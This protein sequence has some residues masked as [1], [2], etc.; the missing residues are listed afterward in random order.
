MTAG[1][2][3]A[4]Y[5]RAAVPVDGGELAV[6]V[7]G[8]DAAGTPIL[9]VHG[10]TASHRAW[11]L[12]AEALSGTRVIAPDL[13]GRGRSSGLPAP[14]G[15]EQHADD[16]ARVLD[17]LGVER[18]V[19]AGHSMGGFVAVRLAERHPDRVERLVLVDGGLPVAAPAGVAPED[20]PAV[21][22]G[23]SLQR[24]GMR[25]ASPEEYVA[26]WR[27]HPAIGPWWDDA[28]ADYVAYDLVGEEP[29]LRSSADPD[30]VS[31]NALELDGSAGYAE[32][33]EALRLPIDFIRAPRGLLDAAPL[34]EPSV[35]AE[36]APRIPTMRVHEAHDVNHYTIVMTDAGLRQ[37]LPLLD[38]KETPS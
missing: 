3:P 31:V 12:A 16:L 28:I 36:W 1:T 15:L 11:L 27:R 9:A 10:I 6:G 26:F 13:R 4:P 24:L 8:P 19:V 34:Y 25:F 33:L 20:V 7:W 18:A 38:P 22:L 5:A 37:F 14:F 30:A 23:P 29:E 35:V 32:E 21:V 17:A 2:A